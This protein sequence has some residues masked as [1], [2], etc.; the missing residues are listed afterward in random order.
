[1]Q[2]IIE[3]LKPIPKLYW[4]YATAV[5]II[6]AAIFATRPDEPGLYT[7]DLQF[8]PV[9]VATAFFVLRPIRKNFRL[10]F[11]TYTAIAFLFLAIDY[12]SESHAGL[13]QISVTFLP[14]FLFWMLLFVRW[15]YRKIKDKESRQAL[16]LSLIA[17]GFYALAFPPLPLGPAAPILLVPWFIVLNRCK[18]GTIMFATFWSGMLFNTINYYWIYNVMHVE[19]APS[20]LILFGLVLLIAFFS[21][22]NVLAAF[23]YTL[24][25]SVKIKGKPWLLVLFPL[26]YAGLEMTRTRGDFSFPWSH[27]G[28]AF[29]NQLE[30][31]QA[32]SVIGIF[33]YTSMIIASNM[34]VEKGIRRKGIIKKWPIIVPAFILAGLA[35]HGSIVLSS[36]EAQPFHIQENDKAPNIALIQPSIAQGA[37]WSK[38]R[39][40]S[41]VDK[42]I[43]M[44]YDSTSDDVDIILMAE[45]AI[46]DHIRRQP[47]VI[48][49][50]QK[51]ANDKDAY[52]LVGALDFKR[53]Q[54]PEGPRR[55]EIYNASFMFS[56]GGNNNPKRYIK[57]HLVP[58]SERIPFDDIFPILNY[59][60]F[61]EGDFVPG[62][63]TPVYS[64]YQWTP[65]ICY[66]AIFGDLVREAA[67][68]GS[69]LMVNI[70]N[71]GWF[72]RST[73]PGNHLNLVRY[74]AIETGMPVARIANSGISAFIDQYGHYSHNT[75]LFVTTTVQRKM[76]LKT[77]HTL[78]ESIGDTIETALLWFFLIYLVVCSAACIMQKKRLQKQ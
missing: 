60:D 29:G 42:T 58:F 3:A 67:R 38:P 65:Y 46:P 27:L 21:V 76:Q 52:V 63:E 72:G 22:H 37:K 47:K 19:T 2:K 51:L 41:I 25:R 15:N 26:F 6:E 56:P 12:L 32:L 43:R 33:G 14:A 55:Y 45:T 11:Y 16:A 9:A 61:G 62:T 68:Q 30:L 64:L 54:D 35:I 78:Y 73:A 74:R 4:I 50:L 53:I 5:L 40:D 49:R 20:G 36:A 48:R 10:S 13:I 66:D 59:V 1:M 75:D 24:A 18:R 70:T 17:W 7:Q 44:A 39:F 23:V 34:I 57:K 31:L 77:R 8:V 71:D 69:R 28:Y